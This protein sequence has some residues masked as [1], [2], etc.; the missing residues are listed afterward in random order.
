M[1]NLES[2]RQDVCVFCRAQEI[3]DIT[4]VLIAMGVIGRL[5][6]TTA[7]KLEEVY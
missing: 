2:G 4:L 5:E 1:E 6:T 7:G 3:V